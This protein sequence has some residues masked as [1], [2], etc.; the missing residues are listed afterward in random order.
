MPTQC[1]HCG[2]QTELLLAP[3]P[4]VSSVPRKAV[5]YAV[6]AFVILVGGL[7]AS[8]VAVKRAQGLVARQK[9]RTTNASATNTP[10]AA[11]TPES[12]AAQAGF[13][14]SSIK[15]QKADRGSVVYAIG[16]V[17]NETDRKRFGVKV[18]L[19]LLDNAGRKVGEARDYYQVLEPQATWQFRALVTESKATS[20][21]LAAVKED[22]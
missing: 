2:K 16:D 10:P 18:E 15:L 14:I 17:K 19:D 9:N 22:Q 13:R 1:P 5:I 8:L 4:Q 6:I 12:I 3:T 7:A 11:P 21:K 20:A